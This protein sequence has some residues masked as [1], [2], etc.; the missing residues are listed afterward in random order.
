M[1]TQAISHN[2]SKKTTGLLLAGLAVGMVGMAYAAV[3]LYYAF[4]AATGYGGTTQRAVSNLKGVVGREMGVR[5][6]ASISNGVPIRVQPA[7]I[8]SDPIGTV[9]TVVFKATNLTARSITTTAS[10]N[11]VPELAGSYFN[12]IECFCFTEQVFAP[13]E[14][15]DMPVTFFVDPDLVKDQ[16]LS[17]LQ[18][19]TLSYTFYLSDNGRS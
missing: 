15:V 6:D 17:T 7:K 11:V 13:G 2:R 9:R 18:E 8:V 19:I 1:G 4:C 3:P 10:F 14:T 12:K 16:D 5:F